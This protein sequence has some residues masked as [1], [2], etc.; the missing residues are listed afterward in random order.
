MN[1][2]L[3]KCVLGSPIV[4]MATRNV[5]LKEGWGRALGIGSLLGGAGLGGW[6]LLDPTGFGDAMSH[7]GQFIGN[8]METIKG[9]ASD[10]WDS[11]KNGVS[12]F[13]DSFKAS[14]PTITGPGNIP[15]DDYVLGA[16]GAKPE[17]SSS[18]LPSDA[19][20]GKTPSGGSSLPGDTTSSNGG[21]RTSAS[22]SHDSSSSGNHSGR[23]PPMV[24]SGGGDHGSHR[25]GDRPI[26]KMFDQASSKT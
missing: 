21:G 10:M 14:T 4:T 8:G 25:P 23:M 20:T 15:P 22:P 13:T 16:D 7:F 5:L 9:G 24:S 2:G 17:S 26:A 19:T 18:S 6:A 11:T 1:T 12:N 3:R